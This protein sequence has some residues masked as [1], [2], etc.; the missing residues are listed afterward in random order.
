MEKSIVSVMILFIILITNDAK[1]IILNAYVF[2]TN[3]SDPFVSKICL[4]GGVKWKTDYFVL[5]TAM[6][7]KLIMSINNTSI[8]CLMKISPKKCSRSSIF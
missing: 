5:N 1:S 8:R 2:F 6:K 7:S 4:K 3:K